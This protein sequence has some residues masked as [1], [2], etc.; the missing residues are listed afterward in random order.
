MDYEKCAKEL[1]QYI[2]VCEH[3]DRILR[4]NVSDLAKGE[5]AVL[6]YLMDENDGACAHDIS[7][8]FHINTSRVAAVLNSLCKKEYIR[9]FTDENDKRKIH[10]YLTKEGTAYVQE[11][12]DEVEKYMADMLKELGENDAK[13]LV[14]LMK[15]ISFL[16]QRMDER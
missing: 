3:N 10:V 5:I 9:R 1:I 8:R 12:R 11:K 14:R 6:S 7:Q 4:N 13:E 2:I 15:K 16:S